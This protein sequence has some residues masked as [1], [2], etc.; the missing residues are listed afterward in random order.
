MFEDEAKLT[1]GY[2]ISQSNVDLSDIK[3]HIYNAGDPFKD[4]YY[5]LV[6]HED[7]KFVINWFG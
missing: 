3:V 6:S 2:Q 7:E 1:L 5:K 4:S